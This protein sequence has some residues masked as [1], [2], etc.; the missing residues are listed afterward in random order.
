MATLAALISSAI[1]KVST[2]PTYTEMEFATREEAR[3]DFTNALL[4]ELGLGPKPAAA[5]APVTEAKMEKKR[6][7]KPSKEAVVAEAAVAILEQVKEAPK[8]VEALTEALGQLALEE[9]PKAKKARKTKGNGSGEPV[10]EP[11]PEPV[12]EKKKPGPKPKAK[13]EGA[14]NLEKLTPTHKKHIKAIAAELK[15]EANEK[16]FLTYANDMSAEEWSAKALD[17]HIRQF[18]QP[19]GAAELAPPPTEFLVVDFKGK[20]YLVDPATKFIYTSTADETVKARSH[21]GVVGL[22]EFKEMEI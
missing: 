15:V 20:E 5:H 6:A 9:Q 3:I 2:D 8:E 18:L 4:F 14:G 17:A 7:A 1:E 12:K 16:E 22:L 13:A 11:V 21:V 10:P 19:E